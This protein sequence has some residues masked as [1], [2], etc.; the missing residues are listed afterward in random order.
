LSVRI[1]PHAPPQ[2]SVGV[3]HSWS[4]QTFPVPQ[5]VGH[6]TELPQLS[7]TL[8]PHLL[9][10]A[11]AAFGV[12]HPPSARHTCPATTHKL[13]SPRKPQLTV[14]LQLLV[15]CPH[16]LLLHAAA[17]DSGWHGFGPQVPQLVGFP[18]LSLTCP[19]RPVHQPGSL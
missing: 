11:A 12:Q 17:I 9:P 10:Q 18:Q 14:W 3:Q 7:V 15:A 8:T 1:T 16:C 19:Q 4:W 5:F 2:A 13:V 6:G